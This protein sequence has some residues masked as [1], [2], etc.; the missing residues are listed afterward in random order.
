MGFSRQIAIFVIPIGAFGHHSRISTLR[1][2]SGCLFHRLKFFK[3]KHF[4]LK[5]FNYCRL[6]RDK[7]ANQ[8]HLEILNLSRI[9][10]KMRV[11]CPE[12]L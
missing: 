6:N 4:N 12:W 10:S 1:H 5:Y 9:L 8:S 2:P 7:R 11:F 3:S